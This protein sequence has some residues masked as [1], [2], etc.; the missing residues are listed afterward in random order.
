MTIFWAYSSHYFHCELIFVHIIV[1]RYLVF[2]NLLKWLN[3]H[4]SVKVSLHGM[5]IYLVVS[6]LASRLTYLLA[7]VRIS[8]LFF[9]AF[10][11][12]CT[13]SILPAYAS[14]QFESFNCCSPILLAFPPYTQL[15]SWDKHHTALTSHKLQMNQVNVYFH[16]FHYLIQLLKRHSY[17]C[18]KY[19]KWHE[20]P[21]YLNYISV[22]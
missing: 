18:S 6:T 2:R 20:P 7:C 8:S 4:N 16:E 17:H 10:I 1:H 21:L 13:K 14:T 5:L 3:G 15:T 22:T 9:I 11:F 19:V 12:S